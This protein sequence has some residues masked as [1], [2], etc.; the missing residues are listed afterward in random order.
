METIGNL[1]K[2]ARLRKS[3]TQTGLSELIG[4]SPTY[5]TAIEGG[6]R[7]PSLGV[8]K[9]LADVLDLDPDLLIFMARQERMS[10]EE[11][12]RLIVIPKNQLERQ[13][14]PGQ[15]PIPILPVSHAGSVKSHGHAEGYIERHPNL[16]DLFAY[17]I[18]IEGDSMIHRLFDGDLVIASPTEVAKSHDL[19][20][21][22]H[23]N[24]RVWV[25]KVILDYTGM[26]TLQS[27]NPLYEPLTFKRKELEFIHKIVWIKPA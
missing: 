3:L 5:I 27:F 10:P 2:G 20:V 8:V 13:G 23:R 1:V 12:E 25:R 18:K 6:T 14:W 22:R 19:A 7:T 15:D 26:V 17:A 4:V 11:R 9:R 21:V 24:D 16:T